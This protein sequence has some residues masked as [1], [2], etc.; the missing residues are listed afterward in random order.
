LEQ[1]PVFTKTAPSSPAKSDENRLWVG[2]K[3]MAKE[4]FGS[5]A[6]RDVRRFNRLLYESSPEDRP[7]VINLPGIGN[8]MR[9]A[10][11]RAWLAERERRAAQALLPILIALMLFNITPAVAMIDGDSLSL[12]RASEKTAGHH[13]GR[14]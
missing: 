9:P 11:W 14:S 2:N 4:A 8:C 7:P 1:A 13:P 10:A 6:P 12:A 5:D 3:G